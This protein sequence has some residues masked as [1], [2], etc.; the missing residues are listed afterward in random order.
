VLYYP[1]HVSADGYAALD[2]RGFV[3]SRRFRGWV[4]WDNGDV[5][6]YRKP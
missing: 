6:V 1:N 2:R 5:L 3:E 4:D